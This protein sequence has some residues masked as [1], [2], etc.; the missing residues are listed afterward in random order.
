M[1]TCRT[2]SRLAFLI[3]LTACGPS[4]AT[5]SAIGTSHARPTQVPVELS[6]STAE[7]EYIE[8][9]D[10]RGREA[11]VV[12]FATFDTPSQMAWMPLASFAEAH[13]EVTILG[14]AIQPDARFLLPPYASALS[15]PFTLAF[16]PE[17]TIL[18]GTSSLGPAPGVPGYVVLDADGYET[19]RHEGLLDQ[20]GL[21]ALL[22]R[23]RS[24]D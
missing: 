4:A 8:I 18:P 20:S 14:I 13:P 23:A 22:S 15:L 5:S 19:T 3:A 12:L 17:E 9:A 11:I 2:G 21:E 24:G 16:D 1:G 10:L 7:G 6:L